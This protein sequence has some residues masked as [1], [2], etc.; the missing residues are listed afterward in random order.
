[1][2][3]LVGPAPA[4]WLHSLDRIKRHGRA[5]T[6]ACLLLLHDP[7]PSAVG[8]HPLAVTVSSECDAATT[9]PSTPTRLAAPCILDHRVS[10]SNSTVVVNLLCAQSATQADACVSCPLDWRAPLLET[11]PSPGASFKRIRRRDRPLQPAKSPSW[12]M[13]KEHEPWN[14][15]RCGS[16]HLC[17]A[18][19]PLGAG[20]FRRGD[21]P[22]PRRPRPSIYHIRLHAD[23]HTFIRT[24][25]LVTHHTL[26]SFRKPNLHGT[27]RLDSGAWLR[28]PQ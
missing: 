24:C 5:P 11:L 17:F 8:S 2:L 13:R 9:H 25:R 21:E 6:T 4:G 15:G 7:V 26:P 1:M 20:I 23:N 16:C 19:L 14:R 12:R 28:L 22:L 3:P 18:G 27:C 10:H